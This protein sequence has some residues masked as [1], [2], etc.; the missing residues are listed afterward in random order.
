M[1]NNSNRN[2]PESN[3]PLSDPISPPRSGEPDAQVV[4]GET[5]RLTKLSWEGPMPPP[6]FLRQYDEVIPGGAN[7]L[8]T[9][10][11]EESVHRRLMERR[12]QTYPLVDQLAARGA[13]LLFA[14]GALG[15]LIYCASIGAHVVA[16]SIGGVLIIAGINAFLQIKSSSSALAKHTQAMPPPSKS[17]KKRR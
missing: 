8:L 15:A 14:A 3:H 1:S 17:T 11:E 16:V 12:S 10:V 9:M 4:R 7:R 13:A 5:M 2:P 6:S